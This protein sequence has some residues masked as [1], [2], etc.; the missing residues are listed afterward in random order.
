M[1]QQ[2]LEQDPDV[3]DPGSVQGC[4]PFTLGWPDDTLELQCYYPTSVL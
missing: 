1:R 2:R 3:L 4:G